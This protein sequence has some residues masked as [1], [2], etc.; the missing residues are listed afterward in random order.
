[1]KKLGLI[2]V[3]ATVTL[4]AVSCGPRNQQ[5]EDRDPRMLVV[6]YSQ[7]SNTKAVATE[8]ATRLNIDIA[9]I[10]PVEPYDGDFEATINRGKKELDEGILPEIKPLTVNVADYDLIFIGYPIWFGTY[11]PPVAT[12]LDQVDL[13]FKQIVP[14]CTFG[15][16]GLE[17]ST[18]DLYEA[19]PKA[20]MIDGF[21]I[22]AARMDAM[23]KEIDYFLK[24]GKFIEGEY[25]PLGDFTEQRDMTADEVDIF[26]AATGD[27]PMMNARAE[28][29]G[30]RVIPGGTEY[31]FVA[32]DLPRE[33]MPDMPPM[34]QMK[35]YVTALD[36]E[37]PVFT[38]VVR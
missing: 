3:I 8:I 35:V 16:G 33:D 19:E 37:T 14:F 20:T 30:T 28:T 9:E 17:S 36:G 13:S 29:V 15:S 7:T 2:M 27:Y 26:E 5:E 6:Y 38:S 21:G 18:K 12:F 24:A 25:T 10:V 31:L 22:R 4:A 23:P 1:M 32:V 34:G 11:P